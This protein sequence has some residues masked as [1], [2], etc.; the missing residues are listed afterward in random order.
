MKRFSVL[1]ILAIILVSCIPQRLPRA[2]DR[3]VFL[4]PVYQGYWSPLFGVELDLLG[5]QLTAGQMQNIRDVHT[6]II[7]TWILY[8]RIPAAMLGYN[9]ELLDDAGITIIAAVKGNSCWIDESAYPEFMTWL[10]QTVKDYPQVDIW[11]IWNEP[12]IGGCIP[13]YFGGWA[14]QGVDTYIR[15]LNQAYDTIKSVNPSAKVMPGSFCLCFPDDDPNWQFVEQVIK[16][17]RFDVIG[18][19]HYAV[20]PSNLLN[21]IGKLDSNVKRIRNYMGSDV[22]PIYL[23]ETS[24]II[25]VAMLPEGC[26]DGFQ[27]YQVDWLEKLTD[28]TRLANVSSLIWYG[29]YIDWQ[30]SGMSGKEVEQAAMEEWR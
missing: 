1:I 18:I 24:A 10:E 21:E 8:E 27:D 30:C 19:H 22:K 3:N 5:G 25:P 12:E 26:T 9:L 14:S 20:Y 16:Q 13:P 11:E 28:Y 17:G 6:R 4:S 29:L 23:D 2:S 15:F 7:R